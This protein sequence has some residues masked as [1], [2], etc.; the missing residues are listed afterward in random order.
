MRDT[1][2]VKVKNENGCKTV[3]FKKSQYIELF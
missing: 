1:F 3:L 2:I